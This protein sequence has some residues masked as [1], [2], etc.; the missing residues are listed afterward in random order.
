MA[1]EV[2]I[3]SD[4][5]GVSLSPAGL[6]NSHFFGKEPRVALVLQWR[7]FPET[8]EDDEE[9]VEVEEEEE[10]HKEEEPLDVTL[11]AGVRV[12]VCTCRC[13]ACVLA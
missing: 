9:G 6:H 11:V 5:E 1:S 8:A 12:C 2:P 4:R 13:V 7:A 10:E 3:S